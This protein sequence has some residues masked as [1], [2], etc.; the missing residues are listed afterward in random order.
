MGWKKNPIVFQLV[1]HRSLFQEPIRSLGGEVLIKSN[2]K[3]VVSVEFF[4]MALDLLKLVISSNAPLSFE[5]PKN[6][7]LWGDQSL[8]FSWICE[9]GEFLL[10]ALDLPPFGRICLE[11]F[12]HQTRKSKVVR[13]VFFL[14][15]KEVFVGESSWKK[16]LNIKDIYI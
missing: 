1:M 10:F 5:S 3:V 16:T 15:R 6:L 9:K 13:C 4:P 8:Y 11:L 2:A 12:L 7:G 14:C